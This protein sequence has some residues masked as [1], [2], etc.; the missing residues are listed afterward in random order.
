MNLNLID[1]INEW[2]KDC[3]LSKSYFVHGNVVFTNSWPI[4]SVAVIYADMVSTPNTEFCIAD[5][6]FFNKL[7]RVLINKSYMWAKCD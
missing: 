5:P 1:I 2:I 4:L 3:D 7:K 6:E